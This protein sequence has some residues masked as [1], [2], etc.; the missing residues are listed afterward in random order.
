L[1]T[2]VKFYTDEHVGQAIVAGLRRRGFDVLSARE[3]QMLSAADEH[4]LAFALSQQRV[5]FTQDS[6]F[7]RLHQAG[8]SHAGIVYVRQRTGVGDIIRGLTLIATVM[9]LEDMS[10]HIEYL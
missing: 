7:I 10:N 6:D 4:H 9:S 5:L 3:A 2:A 8:V 1:A